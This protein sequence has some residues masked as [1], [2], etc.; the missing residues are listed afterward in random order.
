MEE[1]F[2]KNGQSQK[3]VAKYCHSKIKVV[4]YKIVKYSKLTKNFLKIIPVF[5]TVYHW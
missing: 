5:T 4:V 3:I 1:I 2:A